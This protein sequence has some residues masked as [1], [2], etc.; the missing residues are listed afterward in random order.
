MMRATIFFCIVSFVVVFG[1]TEL[2]CP[3]SPPTCSL[4]IEAGC[5]WCSVA[6]AVLGNQGICEGTLGG[7]WTEN[8]TGCP[9]VT[10]CEALA[11]CEECVAEPECG[12]CDVGLVK[13]CANFSQGAIND[14]RAGAGDF[15]G[16]YYYETCDIEYGATTTTSDAN[17]TTASDTT[18]TETQNTEM[19]TSESNANPTSSVP[20]TEEETTS[21]SEQETSSETPTELPVTSTSEEEAT[22]N[23]ETSSSQSEE[24]PDLD[25]DCLALCSDED[26]IDSC[27]CQNGSPDIT[28]KST[29]EST[30]LKIGF[31]VGF[32]LFNY[33]L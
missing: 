18:P 20:T 31:A 24:C 25:S 9:V 29:S 22:Q 16:K 11:T 21:E 4:C 8:I 3:D 19:T 14:C 26:N 28:C 30:V 17:A 6:C 32:G 27:T 10:G 1:Q 5:A 33:F 7:V 23:S 15:T 2:F 13:T 12:F